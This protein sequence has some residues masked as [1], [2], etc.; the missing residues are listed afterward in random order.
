MNLDF[1]S[2]AVEDMVEADEID[3]LSE[4]LDFVFDADAIVEILWQC[5]NNVVY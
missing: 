4:A 5:L 2:C 3:A 1:K